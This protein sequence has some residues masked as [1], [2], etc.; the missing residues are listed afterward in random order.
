[1][2]TIVSKA[3]VFATDLLT[4][5]IDPRFLYHNLRHT[6]RVVEST[7]ELIEGENISDEESEQLLV[8]AWFHDLG[9]TKSYTDHEEQS[10]LLVK[11]FLAE[12]K[13]SVSF[14]E[15]V[16]SLIMATKKITSQ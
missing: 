14:S 3:E 5:N 1:M 12:H 6:Q 7:K 2:S 11:D 16:C 15:I 9:Y 8:A 10:C 13:M 4:G